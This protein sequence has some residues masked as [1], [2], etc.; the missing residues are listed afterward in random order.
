[1]TSR[2][3]LFIDDEPNLLRSI[4][5]ALRNEPFAIWTARNADESKEIL[6]TRS[7]DLIVSDHNMP[8][9]SGMAFL[10]WAGRE[11]PSIP[12]IMLTG[13]IDVGL[14]NRAHEAQVTFFLKPINPKKLAKAIRDALE[15]PTQEIDCPA[16][17]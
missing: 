11:F 9:L 6:M 8:G 16:A 14:K 13:Q 17:Q 15:I 4:S 10:E 2:T 12:R 5:R 1:M 3:I 7:V